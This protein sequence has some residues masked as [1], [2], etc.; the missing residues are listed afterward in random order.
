MA[1]AAVARSE[2]KQTAGPNSAAALRAEVVALRARNAQLEALVE[3]GSAQDAVATSSLESLWRA[4]HLSPAPAS[5][6]SYS[7]GR[8][9]DVNAAFAE[10]VGYSHEELLAMPAGEARLG[11]N[12]VAGEELLRLLGSGLP[13]RAR[14]LDMR[15]KDGSIVTCLTSIQLIDLGDQTCVAGMFVDITPIRREREALARAEERWRKTF[16]VSPAATVMF[17]YE[18]QVVRDANAAFETLTGWTTAELLGRTWQEIGMAADGTLLAGAYA[19]GRGGPPVHGAEAQ[20]RQRSGEWRT[21]L[22]TLELAEFDGERVLLAMFIDIT[23]L[24]RERDALAVSEE[25]WRKAFEA[26][27]VATL[28]ISAESLRFLDANPA[29]ST[30]TGW[31]REEVPGHGYNSSRAR[32][33]ELKLAELLA[34]GQ[35]VRG[36]E[37]RLA[38]KNGPIDVLISADRVIFDGERAILCMLSDLTGMR[39]AEAERGKLEA[40][41]REGERM[42]SLAVLAGGAAHDFNNLLTAIT[43]NANL[44]LSETDASAGATRYLQA[45][46]LA[47]QRA[48]ALTRQML[49]YAG[50]GSAAPEAFDLS[51]LV[52]ETLGLIE[53]SLTR[54]GIVNYDLATDLP[55]VEADATQVRQ[56]VMNLVTNASEA[57]GD[58]PGTITVRTGTRTLD[59][60]FLEASQPV[61]KASPGRF[62]FVEVADSGCGMDGATRARIFDPFYSTK[63][64]GRGLGLAGVAGIVRAHRGAIRVESK[65]G[66]GS[67]FTVLLPASEGSAPAAGGAAIPGARPWSGHGAVL[68]VDD[69]DT[70]RTVTMRMLERSGFRVIAARDGVEALALFVASPEPI[71]IVVLD[72]TLPRMDGEETLRAL[73]AFDPAVRVLLASGYSEEETAARVREAS[74]D[75]YIQKPYTGQSLL[76]QMRAVLGE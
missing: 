66:Q 7:T 41:V 61:G 73:R 19:L 21:C 2:S 69:D 53:V 39:R 60:A 63:F 74:P 33:D 50:K 40:R 44:A 11:V 51:L 76:A 48:G 8:F 64:T 57:L 17:A 5:L 1:D 65:P 27:P 42:E 62:V 13:Y 22:T 52:R 47:A 46:E 24:K 15:R 55:L 26:S 34:S 4:F 10:L 3:A 56:V 45:I 32:F 20:V 70:V 28:I 75:G 58:L 6:L 9:L 18:S 59:A 71:R 43:L 30:L 12:A 67:R 54:R 31:R 37:L 36:V 16:H 25:R 23:E 38:T 68:V 29:F 14:E 49:A 72:M 35:V